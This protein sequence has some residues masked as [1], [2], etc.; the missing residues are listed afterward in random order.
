MGCRDRRARP[1]RHRRDPLPGRHDRRH[2]GR[3][4]DGLHRRRHD[5]QHRA[6]HGGRHPHISR[7]QWTPSV[8][9]KTRLE[10]WAQFDEAS[11]LDER[12]AIQAT[13]WGLFQIMGFHYHA[14]GF[15]TPY[16]FKAAAFTEAG[17]LDLFVR[18]ILA[19]RPLQ[20]ALQRKDWHA[21][22][23]GYNGPAAVDVYAPKIAAAYER[24]AR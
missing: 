1:Q 4:H 8:A 22:A 12:A 16:E 24:H 10:A 19:N 9:A 2:L 14:L 11:A 21:F 20:D 18:F 23:A 15:P 3:R 5:H 6:A 13:S 7:Q 17:Q